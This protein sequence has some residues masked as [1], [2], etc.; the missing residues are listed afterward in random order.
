[1]DWTVIGYV[2]LGW[3]ALCGAFV[4]GAW[5]AGCRRLDDGPFDIDIKEGEL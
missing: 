4:V 5:W 3:L 2:G 1:M